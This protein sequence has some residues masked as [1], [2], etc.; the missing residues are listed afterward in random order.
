[1]KL[2][3]SD[4]LHKINL[5]DDFRFASSCT[6]LVPGFFILLIFITYFTGCDNSSENV[7]HLIK[8][9]VTVKTDFIP[10]NI[11]I[12]GN[13]E[14]L[15]NWNSRG[16]KLEQI[17]SVD[18]FISFTVRSNSVKFKFTGGSWWQEGIDT[19]YSETA[20]Y[21]FM[22][23]SDTTLNFVINS[24]SRKTKNG[25]PEFDPSIL[26]PRSPFLTLTDPWKYSSHDS[27]QFAL[28]EYDDSGWIVTGSNPGEDTTEIKW[29]GSGW[30]RFS[31]YIPDELKGKT[32]ALRISHLG[33]SELYYNGKI[34]QKSGETGLTES[35]YSPV[36]NRIWRAFTF[37][38]SSFNVIAVKYVNLHWK[39]LKQDGFQTGFLINMKD[40][41]SI[42]SIV[43]ESTSR[44]IR[45][46]LIFTLI[47]LILFFFHL[48]L[49][50]FNHRQKENLFF[51][52]SLLGFAGI[53]FFHYQKF[54]EGDP[55]LIVLFYKLNLL[56]IVIS[57]FFGLLTSYS[58]TYKILPGRWK[59]FLLIFSIISVSI[60]LIPVNSRTGIIYYTF[61]GITAVDILF[62]GL[63]KKRVKL[64]GGWI[65]FAGFVALFFFVGLQIL[66]DFGWIDS[67]L[68]SRMVFV[69]GFIG[70]SV[71]MSVFISY[72]YA[73]INKN[74]AQQL[75][76]VNELSQ[77]TIQQEKINSAL[78][79]ERKLI[80]LENE[81]KSKELESARQ[82]QL[83]L[84]PSNFPKTRNL[85]IY[86][87]METASEVGGDYYDFF[88]RDDTSFV[89]VTGDA[90]GHGLKAGNMVMTIKGMLN[91]INTGTELSAL[92]AELNNA[93][94]QMNLKQLYMGLSLIRI[95]GCHAEIAQAGMP[96]VI[97]FRG[98]T[99]ET[100]YVVQK[101]MPAGGAKSFPY[102]SYR[103]EF[104]SSDII[105]SVTDGVTELFNETGEMLG[106]D[107]IAHILKQSHTLS[108]KEITG[109]IFT[110]IAAWAA[111][112]GIKDDITVMVIKKLS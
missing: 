92:L 44:N 26:S 66:I 81:R 40:P 64:S 77:K 48:I 47:P 16:L 62:S 23:E 9:K 20:D 4:F 96:P 28:P 85:D 57:I 49:F 5:P 53:T 68:G 38:T 108:A 32:I 80:S 43:Y 11:Y 21:N 97:I 2:S 17:D 35:D 104:R 95:D 54:Y 37:D 103:T 86:A 14:T 88:S 10:E 25:L 111:D 84:L 45:E 71:S 70:L 15:G 36:Q 90:T 83:S 105:V 58:L 67:F 82:L 72:N 50:S 73:V 69:Y 19:N 46:Q 33:A 56:S 59:F 61:F 55:R 24:W 31:F 110:Q 78:E 94:R 22:I 100:E 39:V 60:F 102:K 93:I 76:N 12:S 112:S 6:T 98:D 101:S 63:S 52:F 107:K 29:D 8:V 75:V 42:F 7:T 99:G 3:A 74:L 109:V 87:G 13:Q 27:I 18:Y 30:F 65:N 89:C 1:M 41:D 34:F 79:L 51:A 106:I 91:M